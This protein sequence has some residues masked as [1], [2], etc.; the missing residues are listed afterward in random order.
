MAASTDKTHEPY[1]TL[2]RAIKIARIILPLAIAAVVMAFELMLRSASWNE[3]TG[4]WLELAFFGGVGPLVTWLT[5]EWIA[6]EVQERAKAE[7]ALLVANRQLSAVGQVLKR[8]L[9]AENLDEAVLAVADSLAQA[10]GIEVGVILGEIYHPKD[11]KFPEQCLAPELPRSGARICLASPP[12]DPDFYAVLASEADSVLEAAMARTKDLLTLY[13]V[14]GEL[15]AEAN[16]ENLLTNLIRRIASWAGAEAG[17]VYLVEGPGSARPRA[18]TG[19]LAVIRGPFPNEYWGK[20]LEEPVFLAENRLALPLRDSSAV[21]ILELVG[22]AHNLAGRLGFLRL[23][24]SQVTQAVRNAQA[25]L[26]GEELAINE[27]RNRIARDIHDGIAQ[28]LAFTAMKLDLV[29]GLWERNPAR[30]K[31]E[32]TQA[33]ATLREQI[34]EVRRSIFALRPVDLERYGFLETLRR[35]TTAFSEQTGIA[36]AL[37]LPHELK[38]ASSPELVLFRVVQEGLTNVAKHAKARNVTI[39]LVSCPDGHTELTVKDDGQ[40]FN[41]EAVRKSLS[42][43]LTQMQERVQSRGGSLEVQSSRGEGT[44]L[45][46]CLPTDQYLTSRTKMMS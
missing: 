29:M 16:L 27:E 46:V 7:R 34:R 5:L 40:G 36:V 19:D 4:F 41:Y 15:R 43:G 18:A 20:A 32:L 33:A 9:A 21:G 38:L 28:S 1:P 8:S 11:F 30:A 35:Y 12:P 6:Q 25:Y 17:A 44:L 45:K 24:A 42:F 37:D 26:R 2:L 39:R 3:P 31:N 23:L 10:L 13:E 22:P 14:E